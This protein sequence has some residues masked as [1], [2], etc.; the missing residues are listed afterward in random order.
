MTERKWRL[1]IANAAVIWI[2]AVGALGQS[3]RVG[4]TEM[5]YPT[6]ER[7]NSILALE[8]NVPAEVRSNEEFRY[9]LRLTNLTRMRIDEITLTEQFS[10]NFR[11]RTVTPQPSRSEGGRAV[12]QIRSLPP[13]GAEVIQIV[14]SAAS[15]EI[16]GCATITFA[17]ATCSTTRVVDPRIALQKQMTPEVVLCDEITVRLTVGNTGTGVARGVRIVDNL[18][19]GLSTPDGR[20]ALSFEVGDVPSGQ[21][22]EVE[23]R[24]R[25]NRPGAYTNTAHATEQGGQTAD[26]SAS[27]TVRQPALQVTKT[28]PGLRYLGRPATFDITVSNRGD[29]PANNTVLVDPLPAGLDFVSAEGAGRF[30]NGRVEW[31]LGTIGPGQNK[32]VRVT[33]MPR[34]RG[35]YENVAVAR[36]F[37]TEAQAAAP[38][39]V[40]GVP[41]IL[42]E[43]IDLVDPIEIGQN[44]TYVIEVTNQGTA[45]DS[46]IIVQCTLPPEQQFVGAEGASRGSL[47]GQVVTFEPLAN[48]PPKAK[49]TYK[50]IT[51]GNAAGDV[52]FRTLIRSDQTQS[53]VEE[54][55][56]THIY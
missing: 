33:V 19:P 17:A 51:K 52:R 46:N 49:A 5:L 22:R 39:E 10:P 38:L 6:G 32:M 36:A 31:D 11:V 23:F 56:S 16:T 48:L 54:T 3:A 21:S 1:P 42:L 4:R 53:P 34:Q 18:P 28:S 20:N 14:G 13:G 9:E 26:A 50:V 55:E 47:A 24:V 43:V 8:R 12:W 27:T 2:L 15:G 35:R 45:E 37:C 40:R 29:A 30:G 25:A 7:S 44:V 41:A